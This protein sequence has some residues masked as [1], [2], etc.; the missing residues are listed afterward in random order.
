MPASSMDYSIK[1]RARKKEEVAR[2]GNLA[3]LV[4]LGRGARKKLYKTRHT[5]ILS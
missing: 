1:N 5:C 3:V 4:E 2:R